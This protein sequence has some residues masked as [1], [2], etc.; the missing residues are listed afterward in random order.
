M[1]KKKTVRKVNISANYI[2]RE[3]KSFSKDYG[4]GTFKLVFYPSLKP[5]VIGGY[6]NA[7]S[8]FLCNS[9][10]PWELVDTPNI[11]DSTDEREFYIE[12]ESGSLQV[13]LVGE[14]PF[15]NMSY[16]CVVDVNYFGIATGFGG[17]AEWK[18]CGDNGKI[19]LKSLDNV[20][21]A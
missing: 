9:R 19:L 17:S 20:T 12:F 14:A 3:K 7:Q 13:G 10:E 2:L 1:D 21:R 8:G 5:V 15:L 6:M 18:Y 4:T 16:N 11:L